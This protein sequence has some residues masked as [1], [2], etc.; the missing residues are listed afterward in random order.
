MG[1]LVLVG[2]SLALAVTVQTRAQAPDLSTPDG[3]TLAYA[4]ALQSGDTDTAW[5]LL[6]DSAKAQ[7]SKDRFAARASSFRIGDRQRLS[8]E[9]VR[10]DGQ[11]ARVD[12]VRTFPSNGGVFFGSS[13]GP[14]RSTVRLTRESAGWRIT[15]PPEP[16]MVFGP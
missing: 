14:T 12:L 4:L 7:T 13:A 6:A 16:F 10:I 2:G 11:S 5:N 9:D 15:T 3:V 8:V 1:V